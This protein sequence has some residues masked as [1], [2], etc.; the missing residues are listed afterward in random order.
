[1]KLRAFLLVAVL[2][3]GAA[4]HA[5]HPGDDFAGKRLFDKIPLEADSE[6][7]REIPRLT[8]DALKRLQKELDKLDSYHATK[9]KSLVRGELLVRAK[10]ATADDSE[11][12]DMRRNY[13]FGEA[14]LA[15][16]QVTAQF[17]LEAVRPD[18]HARLAGKPAD[19]TKDGI[20]LSDSDIRAR[21]KRL[22]Q[23]LERRPFEF[24]PPAAH[25]ESIEIFPPTG[26]IRR[27]EPSLP[28]WRRILPRLPGFPKIPGLPGPSGP[29]RS[30][31]E[32]RVLPEGEGEMG[33]KTM[34]HNSSDDLLPRA[35]E[36][37]AAPRHK[38]IL[39]K[40][41]LGDLE[42]LMDLLVLEEILQD[43]KALFKASVEGQDD[44]RVSA[45]LVRKWTQ[46]VNSSTFA[47]G[48]E[49]ALEKL[50]HG[51]K[52]A[53]GYYMLYERSVPIA[54]VTARFYWGFHNI[55]WAQQQLMRKDLDPTSKFRREARPSAEFKQIFRNPAVRR[56][57]V[58]D[59][60]DEEEK[61]KK[62]QE[63][64]VL[65]KIL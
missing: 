46:Y 4:S 15:G 64:P 6:A 49:Q 51:E 23:W 65:P 33:R 36:E 37:G 7:E 43:A 10:R 25:M 35:P 17:L 39:K 24:P 13:G 44:I 14:K 58:P 12:D 56:Q 59:E 20:N 28:N 40:H 38:R 53:D 57:F 9:A 1:M 26:H 60:D 41:L 63:A 30:G 45:V 21:L 11:L 48:D 32:R 52:V 27:A 55:N 62:E 54:R 22:E 47:I 3:V 18:L 19:E 31:E 5:I 50:R 2:F 29:D 42:S 8:S 34:S 61:K 16:Y